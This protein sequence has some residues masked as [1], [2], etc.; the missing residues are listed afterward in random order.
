MLENRLLQSLSPRLRDA[1]E[2]D[3]E[4]IELHKD[5]VLLEASSPIEFVYFPTT[6]LISMIASLENG[7]AV[8][9]ATIGND[10]FAGVTALLGMDRANITAVVQVPG[11]AYRMRFGAFRGHIADSEFRDKLGEFAGRLFTTIA[12]STACIAFHPVQERL[13]RWLLLVRDGTQSD[14]FLLTQDFI[15][16]MLGVHRPTV[17]VTVR[18]LESAGLIQHRRGRI[19]IIDPDALAEAACECYR[20]SLSPGER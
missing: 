3:L 13:A 19:R 15:A 20:L 11:E 14:E 1:L 4:H 16:V 10:G 18:L 17:T 6:S 9:A 2:S 8:E 12:Q 5:D 7:N